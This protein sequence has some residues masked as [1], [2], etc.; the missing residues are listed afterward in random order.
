MQITDVNKALMSVA[1]IGDAG[2]TVVFRHDGGV[3]RNNSSGEE[4]QFRREN[5]YRLKVKL[6]DSGFTRP[7][8]RGVENGCSK[9]R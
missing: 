8:S 4:T 6:P 9:L 1:K 5:V 2:H 7:G 3:I